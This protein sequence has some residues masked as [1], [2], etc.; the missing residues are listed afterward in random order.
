MRNDRET[1]CNFESR[2][3]VTLSSYNNTACS[4]SLPDS[5]STFILL[6]NTKLCDSQRESILSASVSKSSEMDNN[7]NYEVGTVLCQIKY[8]DVSSII[9][10]LEPNSSCKPNYTVNHSA[11]TQ[12]NHKKEKMV[13]K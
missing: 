13:G 12:P 9:R 8:S 3:D 10:L 5:L 4:A 6:D 2:F 7:I 1:L 11:H